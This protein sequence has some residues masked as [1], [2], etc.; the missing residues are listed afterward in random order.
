MAMADSASDSNLTEAIDPTLGSIPQARRHRE[1]C[2][3]HDVATVVFLQLVFLE[4]FLL[5]CAGAVRDVW[6]VSVMRNSN[7]SLVEPHEVQ[8]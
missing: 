2:L 6:Q 5:R 7:G 4:S 3:R 8:V 1:P